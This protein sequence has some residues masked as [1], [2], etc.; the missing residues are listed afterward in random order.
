[1][2]NPISTPTPEPAQVEGG[3]CIGFITSPSYCA[4]ILM[5]DGTVVENPSCTNVSKI[6]GTYKMECPQFQPQPQPQVQTPTQTVEEDDNND[7]DN[8]NDNFNEERSRERCEEVQSSG[9]D[10]AVEKER[11]IAKEGGE[12]IDGETFEYDPD[13]YWLP[14]GE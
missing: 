7:N 8:D 6:P 2:A 3:K 10:E 11:E 13:N 1:M 5:P 4:N 9:C 14:E 12:E